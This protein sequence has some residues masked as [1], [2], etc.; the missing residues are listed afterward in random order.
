MKH[1]QQPTAFIR[2]VC[3]GAVLLPE[4][5][6]TRKLLGG[7]NTYQVVYAWE[8]LTGYSRDRNEYPNGGVLE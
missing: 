2:D 7:Q 8:L 6:K 3:S 5:R 1:P 4:F